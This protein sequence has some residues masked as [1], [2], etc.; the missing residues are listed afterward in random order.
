MVCVQV[1]VGL[2]KRLKK[3]KHELVEILL[4]ICISN[5]GLREA[6]ILQ[7]T[8]TTQFRFRKC[9]DLILDELM[10]VNLGFSDFQSTP[11]KQALCDAYCADM[12]FWD[13]GYEMYG[14][15]PSL[16]G[17]RDRDQP[18]AGNIDGR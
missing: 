18:P 4:L 10:V 7:L 3:A 14:R 13:E 17:S 11:L 2:L 15:S 5:Q 1:F 6:E 12:K 16:P 8:Q 9:C